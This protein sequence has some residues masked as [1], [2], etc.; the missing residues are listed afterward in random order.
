MCLC[1]LG[2]GTRSLETGMA[3]WSDPAP[4]SS[5]PWK[6]AT[7]TSASGA[8]EGPMRWRMLAVISLGVMALTLNWFDV[9]TAF[10]LIGA[11]FHVGLGPLSLL[12]S[13]Y[14]VGYGLSHIPGGM[15]A[16]RIGMKRTILLGLAVQ[17]MA[18]VMSGLSQS[19]PE[20]ALFRV[21]SG[22]GGSVFVAVGMAAVV[23][24]FRDHDVTLALGITGGAAF[25]AGAAVALYVWIF[26][27]RAVGWHTSLVLAGVFEL[28]VVM[29]TM[30]LFVTP[31]GI[32]AFTGG[33][34]ERSV[35]RASL[36]SRDLWIYGAA[37]LGGYGAYFT[38]SQLFAG[39]AT[40]DRHLS[41]SSG[42]LL[43]ALI[44]LAGIPGSLL[45]GYWAD[46]SKNLRAFIVGP[47]LI[48]AAL[49]ALI[50][51]VPTG[52]L[53]F[54]G[55]GIGFFMIFGFAAWLAVPSRVCDIDH[56]YIGTATG[57]MLTLAAVGGFF[58]P[59]LFGHLVPHTSY[60]AGWIFLAAVTIAFAIVGLIG[61]NPV[62]RSGS[63]KK[64]LDRTKDLVESGIDRARAAVAA[65]DAAIAAHLLDLPADDVGRVAGPSRSAAKP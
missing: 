31:E 45:G 6:G 59:I 47:L 46:R 53:W 28:C 15:L 12:I 40:Q 50:P 4:P 7:V 52:A 63:Q 51:S 65:G 29:I 62:A 42:G 36:A 33:R 10:P 58:I 5:T 24:W 19:Y 37:L 38:T 23:V 11:E 54:L 22:I 57:L 35:L 64:P 60:S 55:I 3:T 30:A 9:A 18:G 32:A 27:Q 17:G 34:F 1:Y 21:V 43:S 41:A 13:L 14:I 26:V 20:L 44:L 56:A 25:S 61:H 16:T 49:L 39:Y 48:V 2:T 8:D